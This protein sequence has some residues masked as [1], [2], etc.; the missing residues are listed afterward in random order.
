M[1]KA[2]PDRNFGSSAANELTAKLLEAAPGRSSRSEGH[3]PRV[4][5]HRCAMRCQN[6][7]HLM[8]TST[9]TL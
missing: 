4:Q 1:R 6:A 3:R 5:Q 7:P 8:C 2:H 9:N